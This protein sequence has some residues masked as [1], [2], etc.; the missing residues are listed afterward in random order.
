[1][2][3]DKY[4][5]LDSK[6]NA[7]VLTGP[8]RFEIQQRK[9]PGCPEGW[10]RVRVAFCGICGSDLAIFDRDPPIP[11]YWPGHEIAGFVEDRLVVINPL[12]VCGRC[13]FCTSGRESVC[14]SAQMISHHLPGG[15]AE[16][17]HVPR[18]NVFPLD[19]EPAVT[20]LI[21]PIASCLH[22]IRVAGDL[23]NQAVKII[24]AGTVGLLLTQLCHLLGASQV[25]TLGRYTSQKAL[26]DRFGS[27][28][29]DSEAAV[30]FLAAGGDGSA[31]QEAVDGAAIAGRIVTLAN[32]Y[33]S[34]PLNLKWL[35]EHELTLRG[36]QRY[37]KQ[38]FLEAIRLVETGQLDLTPLVTHTFP[39]ENIMEAYATA[40]NKEQCDSIKVL[41]S[42]AGEAGRIGP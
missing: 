24:G 14:S 16:Y 4:L 36:S 26:A 3:Q 22:A 8:S 12:L 34:R 29:L 38:N 1:M 10:L 11:R 9:L 17:I 6:M 21:E 23:E 31:L 20:T 39:L 19:A 27:A 37:C 42:A 40:M 25:E 41:V 5:S 28:S 13:R 32:I 35:V 18:E 33:K 15:F 30:T 2:E 7:A